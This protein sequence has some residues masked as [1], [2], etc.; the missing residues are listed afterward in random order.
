MNGDLYAYGPP[1]VSSFT[2]PSGITSSSV[3][4]NGT[5]LVPGATVKFGAKTCPSVTFVSPSQINA[6]VPNGAVAG[7]ISVTRPAG[8]ATSATSFTPTFSI[9]GFS[10]ASGPTG[11]LVTIT[12]VGFN[13]SSTVKFNAAA[14]A[15]VTHVSATQLRA[16]VPSIA[17]SGPITVTNT[18]GAI[19]TATSASSY[20]VTPHSPPTISSF[21]PSSGIT[22]STVTISGAYFSGASAVR[23]GTLAASYTIVS[24][25]QIT[26]TV[27]NGAIPGKLSV[28]TAV[29]TATSTASFTP[30][31]SITGFSPSSGP[32][33]TVV[34]I[35]GIGFNTGSTVK[36]NAAAA[37]SVTHV[38][39]TRLRA[40]V[41]STATSGPI[42]VTNPT[43]P[44]GTATSATNYTKT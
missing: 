24:A 8:T 25:T 31:F 10:P 20:T 13:T 38:S 39:A 15:S 37:A 22:G 11:T 21:T 4:I 36:F 33:G 27:P 42:T 5:N 9:T 28:T 40:T 7:K 34:T 3:T 2:P 35:G 41:P 19:G 14:A 17:T 26:A 43:A 30:T 6:I 44:V 29:A 32:T 23:F 18:T 16:T 12:G 1:T